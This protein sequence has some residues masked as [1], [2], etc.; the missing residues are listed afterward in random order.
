MPMAP[1]FPTEALPSYLPGQHVGGQIG[2][3]DGGGGVQIGI[4][5][6]GGGVINLLQPVQEQ[7]WGMLAGL[8]IPCL[9]A[10][11]YLFLECGEN[12]GANRKCRSC[13]GHVKLVVL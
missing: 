11:G 7:V 13:R 10:L 5:D 1:P 8:G 6:G 2:I 3:Q 9:Q 12:G 4:Q